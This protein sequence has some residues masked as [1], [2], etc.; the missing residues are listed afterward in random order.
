MPTNGHEPKSEGGRYHPDTRDPDDI[1]PPEEGVLVPAFEAWQQQ[2]E[3][4]LGQAE[5]PEELFDLEAFTRAMRR[6]LRRRDASL[7]HQI[8]AGVYYLRVLRKIGAL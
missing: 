4:A 8:E 1:L 3:Q 6:L 5:T 7:Q 2:R